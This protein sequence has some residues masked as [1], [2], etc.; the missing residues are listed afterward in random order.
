MNTTT[1]NFIASLI[2]TVVSYAALLYGACHPN[3][4]AAIVAGLVALSAGS[5]YV[6]QQ[7]MELDIDWLSWVSLI[8]S[9]SAWG[10]AFVIVIY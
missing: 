2:F 8:V 4:G 10:A 5:A 3:R 7:A 1:L 9:L 6:F